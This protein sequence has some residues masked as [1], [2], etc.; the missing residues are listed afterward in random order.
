MAPPTFIA[1]PSMLQWVRLQILFGYQLY[2]NH[3]NASGTAS[4]AAAPATDAVPDAFGWLIY[5]W[6]PNNIWSLTHCNIDGTAM[7]VG[8]AIVAYR[9]NYDSSRDQIALWVYLQIT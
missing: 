4:V 7:K 3:P 2:I 1:V 5:N 6:Y 9:C 8:G